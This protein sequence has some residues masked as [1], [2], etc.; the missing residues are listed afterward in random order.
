MILKKLYD[1]YGFSI[2][3][4]L[5]K[6]YKRLDLTM[7]EVTVLLALLDIY[8]KR[9]SF[10]I[11]SIARRVDYNQNEIAGLVESLLDKGF[12]SINLE[13]KDGKERE[14]FH[15][16]QVFERVEKL[17]LDDEKEAVKNAYESQISETIK[18]FEL[19]LGRVLKSYEL[20]NLRMWYDQQS[21]THE[22]I[23]KAIE[24]AGGQLSVKYVER[25]LTQQIIPD[26]PIDEDVDIA[27]DNLFKKIK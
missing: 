18:T 5:F 25:I 21:Y 27:L 8:K 20:E 16:S 3:K 22:Q 23:T 1:D 14:V 2:E 9:R 4:I 13:L 19:G 11:L 15:L 17:F 12:I 7:P 10:S 26:R 6:E 24:S